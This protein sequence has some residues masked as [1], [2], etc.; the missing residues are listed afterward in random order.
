M[1]FDLSE[2]I[3]L[4]ARW[5]HVMAAIM[6]V[7]QT[8]FFSWLDHR[9][10]EQLSTNP[11]D[12]QAWMVH[13]G[14]FYIVEKQRIPK[15]M[16]ST[17]YWFKWEAATTWITGVVLLAVVYYMGGGLVDPNGS[18][19]AQQAT[20]VCVG[21]LAASWPVYELLWRSPIGKN[22]YVGAAV[23]FCIIVGVAYGL[24]HYIS[25][26]AAY[27]HIGAIFG[28]IM[29]ANVWMR[30]LPAQRAMVKALQNNQ[31]PDLNLG[32]HAKRCSI[33][34]TYMTIPLVFIMFSNHFPTASYGADYN[35]ILLGGFVLVG[36]LVRHVMI[37]MG[38]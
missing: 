32:A 27:I 8:Y 17:L 19:S 37:R 20:W 26:R 35:W 10:P 25:G 11:Q 15:L 14:G 33:H 30:I 3:N 22:A 29:A 16:P 34:N 24:S 28:T 1:D 36:W 13:S 31:Q 5:I 18:V 7:G 21:L 23:S 4:G 6:W 12:N 9:F 2:W 38:H